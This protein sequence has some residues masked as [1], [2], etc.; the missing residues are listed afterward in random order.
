M[1]ISV[2]KDAMKLHVPHISENNESGYIEQQPH[3]YDEATPAMCNG[4]VFYPFHH[5]S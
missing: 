5:S 2:S 3:Y 1:D 4:L